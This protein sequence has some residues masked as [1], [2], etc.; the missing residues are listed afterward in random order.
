MTEQIR[1]G[2]APQGGRAAALG[3]RGSRL[4]VA[5]L[6]SRKLIPVGVTGGPFSTPPEAQFPQLTGSTSNSPIAIGIAETVPAP[7]DL[8]DPAI[9][10]PYELEADR[11]LHR[12]R[13]GSDEPDAADLGEAGVRRRRRGPGQRAA[14]SRTCRATAPAVIASDKVTVTGSGPDRRVA[15]EPVGDGRARI[16]PDRHRPGRQD[17][18]VLVRLL[19]DEADDADEPRAAEHLGPL[20]GAGRR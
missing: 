3:P 11:G 19:G 18:D 20:D 10:A 17:R 8:A 7:A 14:R 15:F 4:Y 12:R 2:E 6:A 16:T 5:G 13:R 9:T 1:L